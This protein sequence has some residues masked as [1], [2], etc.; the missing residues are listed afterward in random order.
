MSP[1][2]SS[3]ASAKASLGKLTDIQTDI[4]LSGVNGNRT[5]RYRVVVAGRRSGKTHLALTECILLACRRSGANIFYLAPT[6]RQAKQV[7]W[8]TLKAMIEPLNILARKPNESELTLYLTNG[9]AIFLKGTDNFDSLRGVGLDFAVL[10]EYADM[11]PRVFTEVLRPALAD[12][13]GHAM[14]IGTPKSYNHFYK[15][16]LRGSDPEYPE[17][18][19]WQLTSYE[20]GIVSKDEIDAARAEMDER[21]FRQEFLASFESMGSRV[22]HSFERS[23]NVNDKVVDNGGELLVGMDF[24]IT[25][26]SVCFATRA[27][28]QL[29]IFADLELDGSNTEEMSCEIRARYPNRQVRVCPDP[30]GRKRITSA[31]LGQTDLTI[32][33]D[34]GFAVDCPSKAPMIIDRVNTV[35]AALR[36]TNGNTKLYLNPDAKSC[37]MSLE[38]HTFREGTRIPDKTSGLDHMADALGYLVVAFFGLS[39]RGRTSVESM[40]SF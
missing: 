6:Y 12:R 23:V 28:D 1:Q 7:A 21:A 18:K 30:S 32:L 14:F 29:H 2:A 24:N 19:S 13:S 40:G 27:G 37:I 3:S 5:H 34:F 9:S 10:D 8:D 17:W 35:N 22:Y 39:M 20:A 4:F 31:N 11:E 36:D 26:M 25:P 16:F 38:G 33:R 15:F